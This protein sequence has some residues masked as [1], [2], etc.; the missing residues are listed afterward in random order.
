MEPKEKWEALVKRE[1]QVVQD[2]QDQLDPW[3]LQAL[4]VSVEEKAPLA[5]QA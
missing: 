5:P 1:K 2:Q 3:V 4:E